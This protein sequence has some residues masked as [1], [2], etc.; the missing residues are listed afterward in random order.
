MGHEDPA[1]EVRF[2]QDIWKGRRMIQ[3]KTG[4]KGSVFTGSKHLVRQENGMTDLFRMGG[5]FAA[6]KLPVWLL[7]LQHAVIKASAS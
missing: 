2:G 3:M 1:P 6:M 7:N 5:N 4:K